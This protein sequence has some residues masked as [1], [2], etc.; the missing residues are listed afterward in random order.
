MWSARSTIEGRPFSRR[1]SMSARQ[2]SQGSST[3]R[4]GARAQETT[5]G[6]ALLAADSRRTGGSRRRYYDAGAGHGSTQVPVARVGEQQK[7]AT[8]MQTKPGSQ[9]LL[10]LQG[11]GALQNGYSR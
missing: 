2:A 1:T 10:L 6:I 4:M 7:E 8:L 11:M 3:L 5:P 9:S